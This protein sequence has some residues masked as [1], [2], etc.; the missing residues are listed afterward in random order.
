MEASCRAVD[1]GP[2]QRRSGFVAGR[3]AMRWMLCACVLGSLIGTAPAADYIP[4]EPLR[5]VGLAK[6]WQLELPLEPGQRIR[7]AYLVEDHAYYGTQDGYVYTVHVPTGVLRWVRPITRSGYSVLRPCHAGEHVI[8]VTPTDFQVYERRTGTPV[9]RRENRFPP[10]TGAISDGE[11]LYVGG[12]DRRLYACNVN[13][14]FYAW[15]IVVDGPIT[16]LPVLHGDYVFV[17]ND[18]GTIYS[19][20]RADKVFHWQATT[21][22]RVTANLVVDPGLGVFVASRDFSLYLL[23][24]DGGTVRWRARLSGP[25][26]EAPVVTPEVA[27]QYTTADGVVAIENEVGVVDQRI[28]WRLPEGR[29]AL[30]VH[31]DFVYVLTEDNW[32][33]AVQIADGEVE[34]RIP[35]TGLSIPLPAADRATVLLASPDGRIFCARPRDIPFPRQEDV[36]GALRPEPEADADTST[37]PPEQAAPSAALEEEPLK[38]RER[39]TPVGGRSKVS[40]NYTPG[41]REKSTEE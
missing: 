9:M 33:A 23:D 25:L 37:A 12:L 31:D 15:R 26:Y 6:F 40:K 2:V 14:L 27:Y 7:D 36:L 41:Q 8:F 16:S 34:A 17:A 3:F 19:C 22:D 10:G 18:G 4:A 39:G 35:T 13:T 1:G 5:A 21:Y 29:E 28:R 20:T 32:L 38:S 24:F 11:R 30:T